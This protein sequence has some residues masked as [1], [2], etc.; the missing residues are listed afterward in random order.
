MRIFIAAPFTRF[1]EAQEGSIAPRLAPGIRRFLCRLESDLTAAGHE[2]F[3]AHSLEGF[4]KHLR[5]AHVCTPFDMLEIQR[6]DCVVAFAEGSMGV[7]VELGWATAMNK[8]IVLVRRMGDTSSS[9]LLEGLHTVARCETVWAP[10]FLLDDW[11][12]QDELC[13]QIV[14]IIRGISGSVT[15]TKS[16]AFLST[17]FGF[18]PVSKAVT[19][20]S[21]LR[22]RRPDIETHFFGKGIDRDFALKANAFDRVFSIDVD[23]PQV[24]RDLVPQL[25]TYEHVVSVLNL[26]LLSYWG[27]DLP[28]LH[29]VDSLAWMWPRLPPGIEKVR[30]YFVQE[31]LVE[32]NRLGQWSDETRLRSVGPITLANGERLGSP[33]VDSSLLLVNFSGCANPFSDGEIYSRYVRLLSEVIVH[34]ARDRYSKV[35][36]CCREEL[37]RHIDRSGAPGVD[38]MVGHFSP[39]EFREFLAGARLVVTAPGITTT[40]EAIALDKPL[41]FLL[42]QNYSQALISETYRKVLPESCSMAFSRFGPQFLLGGNMDERVGIQLCMQYLDEIL[43]RHE[44]E[45]HRM[46]NE[47]FTDDSIDTVQLLRMSAMGGSHRPGQDEILD[48]L[49]QFDERTPPSDRDA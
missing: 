36:M 42:P 47:L 49:L 27:D 13:Q 46:L 18:G 44:S 45:V 28:P 24:L 16:W 8:P 7:H 23:C 9:P 26:T 3:L 12:L 34:A 17:A 5:P 48:E 2:V 11:N 37:L 6:A 29:L 19:I 22:E 25:K 32:T 35:V 33:Q 38:V 30:T 40:L 20:A 4:G 1:L 21:R 31:Y 41:R 39:A 14:A 43:T 10:Q 15:T